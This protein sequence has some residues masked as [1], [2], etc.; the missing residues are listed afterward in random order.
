MLPHA[1][2][3]TAIK[4]S[5]HLSSSSLLYLLLLVDCSIAPPRQARAVFYQLQGPAQMTTLNEIRLVRTE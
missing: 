4:S 1:S 5:G 2:G 3:A